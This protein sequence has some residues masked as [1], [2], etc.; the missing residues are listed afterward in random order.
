MITIEICD[1]GKENL[2]HYLRRTMTTDLVG[3]DTGGYT[4]KTETSLDL[5]SCHVALSIHRMRRKG[6]QLGFK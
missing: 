1:S 6:V 2:I 5:S 3:P 4:L